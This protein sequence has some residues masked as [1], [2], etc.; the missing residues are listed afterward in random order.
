MFS[1]STCLQG[2]AWCKGCHMTIFTRVWVEQHIC[3]T[4]CKTI[5]NT[6]GTRGLSTMWVLWLDEVNW[7]LVSSSL[8][9]WLFLHPWHYLHIF[10]L[11]TFL[12][13]VQPIKTKELLILLLEF[14][15]MLHI[16]N[17][18][19]NWSVSRFVTCVCIRL[20]ASGNHLLALTV[21]KHLNWQNRLNKT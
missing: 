21:I 18:S 1:A 16:A 3:P 10:F 14:A 2:Y 4:P 9:R 5:L 6:L 19:M 8:S 15:M 17:C 7:V 20:R 12:H 11:F 13:V